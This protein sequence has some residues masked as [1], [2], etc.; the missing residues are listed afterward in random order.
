MHIYNVLIVSYNGS[1]GDILRIE[2]GCAPNI[3]VNEINETDVLSTCSRAIGTIGFMLLT[4]RRTHIISHPVGF[5]R[6]LSTCVWSSV[7]WLSWFFRHHTNLN[8]PLEPIHN[9]LLM[10][11]WWLLDVAEMDFQCFSISGS[12][13]CPSASWKTVLAIFSG[14]AT[15]SSLRGHFQ[16]LQDF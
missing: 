15:D 11:F 2:F 9:G 7:T 3:D 4:C 13:R 12:L 10:V 16:A 14:G 1:I 6:G 5:V 8:R